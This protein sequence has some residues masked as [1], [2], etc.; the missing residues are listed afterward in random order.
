MF[1]VLKNVNVKKNKTHVLFSE[2]NVLVSLSQKNQTA[3]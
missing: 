3:Y 1:F 2:K